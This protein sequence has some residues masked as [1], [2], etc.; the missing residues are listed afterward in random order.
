MFINLIL[1]LAFD[2]P[3]KINKKNILTKKNFMYM[4]LIISFS[5]IFFLLAEPNQNINR[6]FIYFQF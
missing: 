4:Y 3:K 5:V 6:E 1:S 2:I